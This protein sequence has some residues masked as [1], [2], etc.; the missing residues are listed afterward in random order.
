MRSKKFKLILVVAVGFLILAIG[1]T[2]VLGISL[3]RATPQVEIRDL[4]EE[5]TAIFESHG[6]SF[7]VS[8]A[9]IDSLEA[10]A[11]YRGLVAPRLEELNTDRDLFANV[12]FKYP[13]SQ[14]EVE[15]IL[16]KVKGCSLRYVSHPEGGGQLG[17]PVTEKDMA[18]L[19]EWE[20][21]L[22][23]HYG[24]DFRILEGFTAAE[25]T[26]PP[27]ILRGIAED[28]RV[29]LTDVG[30]TDL[31]DQFLNAVTIS[32]SDVSYQYEKYVGSVCNIDG[33]ISLTDDFYNQGAIDN[34]GVYNSL[35]SKLDNA[36][37]KLEKNQPDV[38]VQML[39]A[40][41]NEVQAQS[42]KHIE[43]GAADQLLIV[44]DCVQVTL[45]RE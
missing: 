11:K 36:K 43:T 16:A 7:L 30:A 18:D 39:G 31:L 26:A 20:A 8:E 24:E 19:L 38:A 37:R 3:A 2:I 27:D 14:Q 12:S 10:L 15:E 9:K 5:L 44:A 29:F 22:K 42:G 13:L 45:S 41:I 28:P 40:F 25:V 23:E 17:C 4:G 6:Y 21:D 34:R 32:E 1:A 33:L 35:R